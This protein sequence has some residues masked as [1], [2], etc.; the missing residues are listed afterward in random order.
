MYVSANFVGPLRVGVPSIKW[1]LRSN[2]R[3]FKRAVGFVVDIAHEP[4]QYV[5]TSFHEYKLIMI[6][7]ETKNNFG[8]AGN[9]ST[10]MD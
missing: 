6:G 9:P 8:R 7:Y 5:I 10:G 2:H 3:F 4:H 1:H